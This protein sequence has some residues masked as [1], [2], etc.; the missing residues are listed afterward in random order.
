MI[1]LFQMWHLKCNRNIIQQGIKC[2]LMLYA[3]ILP[4]KGM[5]PMGSF[6]GSPGF[7]LIHPTTI[8]AA[9][10]Q[11]AGFFY[12]ADNDQNPMRFDAISLAPN[13]DLPTGRNRMAE[14][15]SLITQWALFEPPEEE[16]LVCIP[17]EDFSF[18][19][20]INLR[21]VPVIQ[22]ESWDRKVHRDRAILYQHALSRAGLDTTPLRDVLTS[23][24]P[25]INQVIDHAWLSKVDY[26]QV[27]EYVGDHPTLAEKHP[28]RKFRQ[29]LW[30]VIGCETV[31]GEWQQFTSEEQRLIVYASFYGLPA[32][33]RVPYQKGYGLLVDDHEVI[34]ADID[35][36]Y[37]SQ[38]IGVNS[39]K[40][41]K[42]E[43]EPEP[44]VSP[45]PPTEPEL[46]DP[47]VFDPKVTGIW[48]HLLGLMTDEQKAQ[49]KRTIKVKPSILWEN[50]YCSK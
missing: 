46:E 44:V 37:H 25:L 11:D 19:D 14:I 36:E 30:D 12:E 17:P 6:I 49:L 43:G 27:E 33:E 42:E 31:L 5:L 21:F 16:S 1:M 26:D 15:V 7:G 13:F 45:P 41:S 20:F 23:L 3:M 38:Y 22:R 34:P 18:E 24:A 2:N 39:Y 9:V 35:F 8:T 28:A 32:P 48:D 50:C 40:L 47:I 4:A 10:L 29:L